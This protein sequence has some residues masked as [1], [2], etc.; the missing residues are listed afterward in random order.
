MDAI[1]EP[2]WRIWP[3]MLSIVLGAWVLARS[4]AHERRFLRADAMDMAKPLALASGLRLMLLGI[5]LV[6]F[7][8]AWIVQ[9]AWLWW[10]ALIFGA[11]ETWETSMIVSGLRQSDRFRAQ[12][13]RTRS[14]A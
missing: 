13:E 10:L 9:I 12:Y 3:S 2:S 6:A 7:G 4:V 8:L 11:E 1:F 14:R 5:S